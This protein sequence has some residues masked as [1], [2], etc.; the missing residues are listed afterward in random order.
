MCAL[1]MQLD[2]GLRVS[3]LEYPSFKWQYPCPSSC[4][5][6]L[7]QNNEQLVYRL[8]IWIFIIGA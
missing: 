2:E 7:L 6:L 8:Q 3:R 4:T 1:E 5:V